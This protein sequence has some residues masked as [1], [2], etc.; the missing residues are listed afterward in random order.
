[1]SRRGRL[2]GFD[3][4]DALAIAEH[5]A[6]ELFEDAP[7]FG[8][9]SFRLFLRDDGGDISEESAQV[10]GLIEGGGDE[11][12]ELLEAF[13]GALGDRAE[14]IAGIGDAGD[15]ADDGGDQQRERSPDPEERERGLEER[16]RSWKRGVH[17]SGLID[18]RNGSERCS[19][20]NRESSIE[21]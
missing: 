8:F 13:A 7:F 1:M 5:D 15:E 3:G 10:A 4:S 2:N 21:L 14:L 12:E 6:V 9:E 18:A 20:K 16:V 11:A 19:P 17:E